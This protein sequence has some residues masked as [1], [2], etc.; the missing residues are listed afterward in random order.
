MIRPE[1]KAPVN[2]RRLFRRKP[3]RFL[4]IKVI[5]DTGA[6]TRNYVVGVRTVR[7]AKVALVATSILFVA[8]VIALVDGYYAHR[9]I[10]LLTIKTEQ[11]RHQNQIIAE[12]REELSQIWVINER[13]QRMLGAGAEPRDRR[14]VARDLP[15]GRPLAQWAGAPF[16]IAPTAHPEAGVMFFANP[17]A[18]VLATAQGT[19]SD[20]RW[21]PAVGDV[22]VINHTDGVQTR[23]AS[24]LT[25]LAQP[26]EPVAQGQ[27]VG[28]IRPTD[29]SRQP[30]L[31][32]QVI[33]DG[34]PVNPLASM[35]RDTAQR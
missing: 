6:T 4:T 26:G 19:V 13:L 16:R 33:A 25:F 18:L 35:V 1:R 27:T 21:H 10:A 12:L 22:L 17:G 14:P 11:L 3:D 23:Y 34:Q 24:D 5:T 8:G 15:W 20:I 31:F 28:V 32:Y 29:G 2:V 30:T 9:E 7:A